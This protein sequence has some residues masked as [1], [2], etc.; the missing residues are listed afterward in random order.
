MAMVATMRDQL[1]ETGAAV[2]WR[3]ARVAE[4]R[5][6]RARRNAFPYLA[7]M[8]GIA[9][10][11]LIPLTSELE[12]GALAV[13]LGLHLTALLLLAA[14]GYRAWSG[15]HRETPPVDPDARSRRR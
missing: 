2:E 9:L 10:L 1:A 7:G 11:L 3:R 12:G 8:F 15:Q 6:R 13:V 5:Q 4:M 14:F